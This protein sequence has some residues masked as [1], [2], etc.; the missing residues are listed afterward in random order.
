MVTGGTGF[1]GGHLVA[2]LVAVGHKPHLLVRDPEKLK[3]LCELHALDPAALSFTV[4]DITDEGLVSLALEGCDAC[5]HAAAVTSLDPPDRAKMHLI[6]AGGARTVLDAAVAAGCEPVIHVSSMGVIFP[7][8]GGRMSGDDP[9]RVGGSAYPASKAEAELRARGLQASGQPVVIVYPGGVAGPKD[10]GVNATEATISS[11][12]E[13]PAHIRPPTGGLLVVDVRDLAAALARLLVPRGPQRYV[14][15]GN[16]LTWDQFANDLHTVTGVSRPID[17]LTEQDTIA[18]FGRDTARYMLSLK[19]RDDWPIR[20]DTTISWRPFTE[21]LA[22]L[23]NWMRSRPT[24]PTQP[25]EQEH[26]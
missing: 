18:M 17:D 20:R 25:A 19:P 16:F 15:G 11:Y 24:R 14:A 22:D 9:V 1:I 8:T 2:A 10:V 3:Q 7:P 12:L 5:V 6:N 13:A 23:L 26:A 4:G 21:T